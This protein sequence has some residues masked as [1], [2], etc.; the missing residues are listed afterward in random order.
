MA[1]LVAARRFGLTT[2]VMLTLTRANL[3]QVLPLGESLRGLTERFTFNRLSQVGNAADLELPDK[4]QFVRLLRQY[5]AARRTNPVL[6]VK[7]NLFSIF[8]AAVG[9]RPF[10]GLHGIWLRSG[11]QFRRPA[12]RR[13]SS[14][15]PQVSFAAGQYP[16]SET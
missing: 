4:R 14:C 9:R 8:A 6:G 7:E 15:L 1:F 12:A 16:N 11:V 5:L 13:R 3:D 2:H 10:P